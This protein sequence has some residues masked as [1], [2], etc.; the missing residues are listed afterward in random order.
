MTVEE[1]FAK[2]K[3]HSIKGIMF[4]AQ[5]ADYFDFLNLY[6]YRRMHE[7]RYTE[8]SINL[9]CL[10][11]HYINQYNRL[12]P[13]ERVDD[14]RVIPD[15]WYSHERANVIQSER[16]TFIMQ[17]F[18]KWYNWEIETKNLYQEAYSELCKLN[19]MTSAGI[20]KNM[21]MSTEKELKDACKM[22]LT[23]RMT[24]YDM[25]TIYLCQEELSKKYEEKRNAYLI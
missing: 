7:H 17:A 8:E 16:K 23:L 19:E 21:L 20:V 1:I 15:N 5:M 12:I 11:K 18:D 9:L 25:P 3:R 4:H 2:L 14:P 6:G 10:S 13:E 24:D 22:K